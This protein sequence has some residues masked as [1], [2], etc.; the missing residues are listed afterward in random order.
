MSVWRIFLHHIR[1]VPIGRYQIWK[2]HAS[3]CIFFCLQ[4]LY[5]HHLYLHMW[6]YAETWEWNIKGEQE[7]VCIVQGIGDLNATSAVGNSHF[8]PF[9]RSSLF[10]F[11]IIFPRCIQIHTCFVF[12]FN[13]SPSSLKY[14]GDASWTHHFIGGTRNTTHTHKEVCSVRCSNKINKL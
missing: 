6:M 12:F 10:R 13:T 5:L 4:F 8:R 2:L 14:S 1:L 9:R 3:S 7:G 11:V